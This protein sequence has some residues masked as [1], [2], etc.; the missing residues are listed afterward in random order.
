VPGLL[1]R[2]G[3]ATGDAMQVYADETLKY[4]RSDLDRRRLERLEQ[5]KQGYALERIDRK[6]EQLHQNKMVEKTYEL[7]GKEQLEQIKQGYALERIDRQGDLSVEKS[8]AANITRTER[9]EQLHQNKMAEVTHKVEEKYRLEPG[10][11]LTADVRIK[12]AADKLF[13]NAIDGP[14]FKKEFSLDRWGGSE[15]RAK[16]DVG[17]RLKSG[18]TVSQVYDYLIDNKMP[19]IS[20][21]AVGAPG[22]SEISLDRI[23]LEQKGP[24]VTEREILTSILNESQLFKLHVEARARL[25]SL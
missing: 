25:D 9:D 23:I 16:A 8:T 12:E 10:G 19:E 7:E 22:G 13:D 18:W 5:I 17:D 11:E 3:K 21:T 4:A 14:Y 1:S 6:G 24:G 2:I 20:S 15:A